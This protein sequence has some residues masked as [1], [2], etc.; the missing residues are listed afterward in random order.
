MGNVEAFADLDEAKLNQIHLR[1]TVLSALGEFLDGYDLLIIVGALLLIVPEFHLAAFQVGGLA[2]AAY[3]GSVVGSLLSGWIADKLGRRGVMILDF[4]LFVVAAAFAAVSQNIT[5]LLLARFLIGVGIGGDFAPSYSLVSEIAPRNRRGTLLSSLQ[6]FWGIGGMAAGLVGIVLFRVGG[7]EAWRWMFLSAV[8]PA[9]IVILLR[10]SLPE[11]PRWLADRG[12]GDKAAVAADMLV[13]GSTHNKLALLSSQP[14]LT[15]HTGRDLV[16]SPFLGMIITV[17]FMQFFNTAGGVL[18]LVYGPLLVTELGLTT[19]IGGVEFSAIE[20][21]A[22]F[23]GTFI[24]MV[25][26]EKV[27]RRA[28]LWVCAAFQILAFGFLAILGH[29]DGHLIVYLFPFVF[30]TNVM[31]AVSMYTWSAEFFP[32]HIRARA[33]GILFAATRLGAVVI[34]LV[35]PFIILIGKGA[36]VMVVGMIVEVL[37][38]AIGLIWWR[39]ETRGISLE[40][41]PGS[42]SMRS[43]NTSQMT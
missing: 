6:V 40:D 27:G 4:V 9:I 13:P 33:D 15:K 7:P 23:V 3:G 26:V 20:F 29:T 10:R 1:I 37:V 14:P 2:T 43:S 34:G 42:V 24:N 21:G 22:F 30:A 11:S 8:I 16:R 36:L 25:L 38:L 5:E 35:I 32:T 28:I 31:G 18:L 41:M 12:E 17:G 39:K 19:K